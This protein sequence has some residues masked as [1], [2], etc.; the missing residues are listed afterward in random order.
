M[1]LITAKVV[2]EHIYC[3]GD[4]K[5]TYAN[6]INSNPILSGSIKQYIF[7]NLLV[8]FAGCVYSFEQDIEKYRSCTSLEEITEIA[9]S[10]AIEYEVLAASFNPCRI[11]IVKN[12]S[13]SEVKA[14]FIGDADAFN[15]YQNYYHASKQVLSTP[16]TGE[17]KIFQLPEPVAENGDYVRMYKAMK[18]VATDA[19]IESVGGAV[20]TTATHKGMFQYMMYCDIFTDE[21]VTPE[22]GETKTIGFGSKEGG[23]YAVEFSACNEHGGLALKPVYYFLQGGF[24]VVF[25][26]NVGAVSK[27][28]FIK[29][30]NPCQ[31]AL[32]TRDLLGEGVISGYL[33]LDHC[34]IEGEKNIAVGDYKKA[35]DCYK[36]RLDSA[37]KFSDYRPKLDRYFSGYYVCLFNTGFQAK[38]LSEIKDLTANNHDFENRKRYQNAM[39]NAIKK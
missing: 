13:A 9:V 38:A 31:W 34:G 27:A 39:E 12:K 15:K 3:I 37:R 6:D 8:C 2:G 1:S 29:A 14:G 19:G 17:I 26:E 7:N 30:K 33:S 16:D 35:L 23:G 5:I 25:P 28:R 10:K 36:L 21:V 24:G 18:D 20:I 22:P 11:I 32:E 4:T